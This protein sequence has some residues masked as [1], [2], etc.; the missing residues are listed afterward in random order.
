MMEKGR[1][2]M[3]LYV[4]GTTHSASSFAASSQMEYPDVVEHGPRGEV[5]TYVPDWQ[6]KCIM[7]L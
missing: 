2:K 7:E 4:E 5:K 3:E 1:E 6:Q